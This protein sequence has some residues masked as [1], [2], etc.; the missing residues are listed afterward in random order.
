M[1]EIPSFRLTLVLQPLPEPFCLMKQKTKIHAGSVTALAFDMED[2]P[3]DYIK[4]FDLKNFEETKMYLVFELGFY[5]C[6]S[7]TCDKKIVA[8][9][10]Q[11]LDLTKLETLKDIDAFTQMEATE[12]NMETADPN[13]ING[14]A[15][16]TLKLRAKYFDDMLAKHFVE[17]E[18]LGIRESVKLTRFRKESWMS[19]SSSDLRPNIP[20]S[21]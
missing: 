13:S 3:N 19:F 18:M 7:V 17:R 5:V 1:D 6:D 9:A 14:E 10:L 15:I 21:T 16:K 11:R 8:R 20:F 4:V 12:L 2:D